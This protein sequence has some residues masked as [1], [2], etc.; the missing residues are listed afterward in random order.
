MK[1]QEFLFFEI[2]LPINCTKRS[3]FN[4]CYIIVML[5]GYLYSKLLNGGGGNQ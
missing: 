5:S 1:F 3:C 2:N 4:N